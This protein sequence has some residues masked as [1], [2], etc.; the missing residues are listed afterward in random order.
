MCASLNC[1][2]LDHDAAAGAAAGPG[3]TVALAA[4][5]T[6]LEL[7]VG[8]GSPGSDILGVFLVG[9]SRGGD[10]NE[11]AEDDGGELHFLERCISDLNFPKSR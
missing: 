1:L 7:G 10:G 2:A 6:G 11:E 8:L 5:L 4:G 3:A 9:R